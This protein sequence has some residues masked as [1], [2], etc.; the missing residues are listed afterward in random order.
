[1]AD[2]EEM[3]GYNDERGY[4]QCYLNSL[5]RDTDDDGYEDGD[6]AHPRTVARWTRK[7]R[8]VKNACGEGYAD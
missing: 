8:D 3:W 5:D 7:M 1:M 6:D 4:F 2:G